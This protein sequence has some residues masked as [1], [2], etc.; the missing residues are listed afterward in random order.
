MATLAIP[1]SHFTRKAVHAVEAI[2]TAASRTHGLKASTAQCSTAAIT[3]RRTTTT[4]TERRASLSDQWC[5]A[6]SEFNKW[7]LA[8]GYDDKLQIDRKEND[9][10]FSRE[11]PMGHPFAEPKQQNQQSP[12]RMRRREP[13]IAEWCHS[14]FRSSYDADRCGPHCERLEVEGGRLVGVRRRR[15]CHTASSPA[16]AGVMKT[17]STVGGGPKHPMHLQLS[18]CSSTVPTAMAILRQSFA[19]IN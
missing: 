9:S 18:P 17:R 4:T 2:S 13:D 19:S 14:D 6:A 3:R 1:L 15:P 16:L 11:L 8:N 5:S 10:E 7:A 12:T